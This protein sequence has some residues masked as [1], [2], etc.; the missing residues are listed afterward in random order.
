MGQT[1]LTRKSLPIFGLFELFS[2]LFL[3]LQME[4][5]DSAPTEATIG[6]KDLAVLDF[7]HLVI[8]VLT[9]GDPSWRSSQFCPLVQHY[10]EDS[11]R[12]DL[13]DAA[14]QMFGKGKSALDRKR[15]GAAGAERFFAY[16]DR[17]ASNGCGERNAWDGGDDWNSDDKAIFAEIQKASSVRFQYFTTYQVIDMV[18]VLGAETAN[19]RR[20]HSIACG[21]RLLGF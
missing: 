18:F 19:W 2:T 7:L 10:I 4:P 21:S 5:V 12:R 6:E 11:L 1:G 8:N 3:S 20:E 17:Y 15:D 14:R 16:C 13:V 9:N